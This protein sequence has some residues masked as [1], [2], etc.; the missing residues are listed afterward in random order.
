MIA[1]FKFEN[2]TIKLTNR[3]VRTKEWKEEEEC[4]KFLVDNDILYP[5]HALGIGQ[6]E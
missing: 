5:R 4:Q 1:A 2:G 3:F 6:V